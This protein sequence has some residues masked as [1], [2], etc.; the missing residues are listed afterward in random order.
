M[1]DVEKQMREKGYNVTTE[2]VD[3]KWKSLLNDYRL[4]EDHNAKS[5]ND[6]KAPKG[7]GLHEYLAEIFCDSAS[8]RPL[9]TSGSS[10]V[11]CHASCSTSSPCS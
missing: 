11:L 3:N 8:R 9:S 10:S 6:K 2:K 7:E 4:T 1:A 5:G